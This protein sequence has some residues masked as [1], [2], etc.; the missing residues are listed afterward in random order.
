[1]NNINKVLEQFHKGDLESAASLAENL[2]NENS[3]TQERIN[4]LNVLGSIH[5]INKKFEKA[6]ENFQAALDIDDGNIDT[7]YNLAKVLTNMNN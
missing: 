3:D 5:A 2:L 1:M 4:L 6:R 7:N